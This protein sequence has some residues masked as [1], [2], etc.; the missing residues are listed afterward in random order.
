[1]NHLTRHQK[2]TLILWARRAYEKTGADEKFDIWRHEQCLDA[3]QCP[4]I[5]AC[6]QQQYIPLLNHFRKIAGCRT[7][8]T[9]NTF[10]PRE[11]RPET[12]NIRVALWRLRQ[13][14]KQYGYNEKYVRTIIAGR[15]SIPHA[16]EPLE[17][18][19]RLLGGRATEQIANTIIARGRAHQKKQTCTVPP[20]EIENNQQY[21]RKITALAKQKKN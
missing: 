12:Q 13:A 9:D 19:A 5:S 1:M 15:L 14:M 18:Y 8:K 10:A 20:F 21:L 7:E 17:T 4:G 16:N 2:T 3:V 11:T 6:T